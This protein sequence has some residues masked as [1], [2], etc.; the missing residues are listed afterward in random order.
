MYSF[1]TKLG[2]TPKMI[3]PDKYDSRRL[4][5]IYEETESLLSAVDL[6]YERMKED[7]LSERNNDI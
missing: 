3:Q 7:V 6:Y 2:F 1:L 5:W 4:I